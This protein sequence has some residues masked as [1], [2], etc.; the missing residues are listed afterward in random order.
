MQLQGCARSCDKTS[1]WI[2]KRGPGYQH[3]ENESYL[4][5]Y[6]LVVEGLRHHNDVNL[7]YES[8]M[9]AYREDGYY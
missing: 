8:D 5:E 7:I 6:L 2:F 9:M 3:A 4:S 1:Y